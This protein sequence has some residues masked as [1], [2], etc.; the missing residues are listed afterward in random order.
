MKLNRGEP[1][2]AFWKTPFTPKEKAM[3]WLGL[4]SC[5]LVA[6]AVEWWTPSQPPFT[7]RWSWLTTAAYNAFGLHGQAVLYGIVGALCVIAACVYWT[8]HHQ[9]RGRASA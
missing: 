5:F 9:P 4:G 6:S 1:D 8:R 7:G 3:A 2:H